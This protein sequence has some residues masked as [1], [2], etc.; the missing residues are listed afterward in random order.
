MQLP[1]LSLLL[2]A[3]LLPAP[4]FYAHHTGLVPGLPIAEADWDRSSDVHRQIDE[5]DRLATPLISNGD[6]VI[7][8]LLASND[9]VQADEA[10]E[11]DDW[12][13]LYNNTDADVS[14]D[15]YFLSDK[16]DNPEKWAFPD[17]TVI[18]A[19][20]YLIV[21]ADEDGD[22]GAL[23]TNFKLSAGGETLLLVDPNGAIADEITFGEQETDVSFGRFPNGTGDF[24]ALEPT[25]GASNSPSSASTPQWP[26]VE[27]RLTPNPA[28][29]LLQIRLRDVPAGPLP[30]TVHTTDGRLVHRSTL[31]GNAQLDCASWP[32]GLYTVMVGSTTQLVSVQ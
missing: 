2:S 26:A 29:E 25:F 10:G 3:Y 24:E 7:N 32:R 28:S 20:D 11:F 14:L 1:I 21:W 18:G 23:H 22:Q 16:A 8:E 15:G 9:A 5:N 17:G 12:I 19:G 13:E 31:R 27:L 30:L 6:V 4:H